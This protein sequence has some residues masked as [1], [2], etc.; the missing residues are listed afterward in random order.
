MSIFRFT[1]YG[2]TIFDL[3]HSAGGFGLATLLVPFR[4][5]ALMQ[6]F[7]NILNTHVFAGQQYDEVIDHVGHFVRELFVGACTCLNNSFERFFAHL[8]GDAFHTILKQFGGITALGHLFMA[9]IDEVLQ[10]CE[11]E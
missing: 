11:E 7:G 10:F 6:F 4:I 8:M 3:F 2:F 5:V 9:C 1:I